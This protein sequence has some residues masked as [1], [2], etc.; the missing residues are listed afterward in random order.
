[1]L[2]LKHV[3]KPAAKVVK[4]PSVVEVISKHGDLPVGVTEHLFV[5]CHAPPVAPDAVAAAACTEWSENGWL[6][7]ETPTAD[8]LVPVGHVPY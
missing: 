1:M 7:I 3:T 6:A 2:H 8:W 5:F 4:P